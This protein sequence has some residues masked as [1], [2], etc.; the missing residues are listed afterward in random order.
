MAGT[1][2]TDRIE[3]DASYA[4]SVNIASPLVIANTLTMGSAAS[5]SGNVNIDSGLIFVD[6][7][8]NRVGIGTINPQSNYILDV[9]GN[10]R[11]GDGTTNEQDMEFFSANGK[12]QMGTNNLAAGTNQTNIF[13]IYDSNASSYRFKIDNSGR[14]QT[15]SQPAFYASLTSGNITGTQTVL[16][17]NVLTNIGS[18]YNSSTGRFTAPIAGL[19]HFY[20]TGLTNGGSNRMQMDIKVNGSGYTTMEQATGYSWQMGS[21]TLL[22][23]LAANDYV[24]VTLNSSVDGMYGLGYNSFSG[25]LIG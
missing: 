7:V 1:I 13:Y 24:T 14:I 10:M 5:I 4:S 16:F 23:T 22:I 9:R 19:Y 8:N 12:W 20:F 17:N 3:S 2:V 15:P 18:H 11:L 6:A 21:M 25:R